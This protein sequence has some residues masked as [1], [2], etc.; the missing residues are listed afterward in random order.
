MMESHNVD[1]G[2]ISACDQN[3][4]AVLLKKCCCE[5]GIQARE[6]AC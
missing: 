4:S 3:C 5:R 6:L 1:L 2:L